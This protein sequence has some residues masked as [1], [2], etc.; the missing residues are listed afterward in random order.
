[1]VK[2][3]VKIYDLYNSLLQNRMTYWDLKHKTQEGSTILFKDM[4]DSH[5]KNVLKLLKKDF[6]D[7]VEIYLEFDL[8]DFKDV[9][10]VLKICKNQI[11]DIQQIKNDYYNN[12]TF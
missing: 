7:E 11:I 2:C 6:L 5:I 1:M 9:G 10:Q 3:K 12:L 8:V 4:K